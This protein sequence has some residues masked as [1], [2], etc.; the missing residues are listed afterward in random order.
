M[1]AEY[2]WLSPL[3]VSSR[4][5]SRQFSEILSSS[6]SV[7][8]KSAE[9]RFVFVCWSHSHCTAFHVSF[10]LLFYDNV[11]NLSCFL[12]FSILY[13]FSDRRRPVVLVGAIPI[14][15]GTRWREL[16]NSEH[17]IYI[18]TLVLV[19]SSKIIWEFWICMLAVSLQI[20]IAPSSMSKF[21]FS[22]SIKYLMCPVFLY[23]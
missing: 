12:Y 21:R 14:P 10:P 19:P 1:R 9:N 5:P 13:S 23:F 11:S 15:P 18:Y 3:Q 20:T 7:S 6:R 2:T 16:D 8:I 17:N 4:F 22:V